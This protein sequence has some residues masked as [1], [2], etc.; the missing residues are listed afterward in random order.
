MTVTS[1]GDI[2]VINR[3]GA[4]ISRI[5]GDYVETVAGKPGRGGEAE[6]E[7]EEVLWLVPENPKYKKI[8]VTRE[9]NFMVWGVVTYT[10]K[11]IR[12]M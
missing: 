2:Y 8:K 11:K 4:F 1:D 7:C 9:Q 12:K 5:S 10:I 3:A 6:H